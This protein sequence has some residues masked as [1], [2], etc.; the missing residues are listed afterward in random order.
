MTSLTDPN[1]P[2]STNEFSEDKNLRMKFDRQ[3]IDEIL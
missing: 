3:K 1:T 2:T